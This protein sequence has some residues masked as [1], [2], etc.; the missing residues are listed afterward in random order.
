MAQSIPPSSVGQW[1]STHDDS[2]TQR[3]TAWLKES[4]LAMNGTMETQCRNIDADYVTAWAIHNKEFGGVIMKFNK[5]VK[6]LGIFILST[7]L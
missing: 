3:F 7:I 4:G 6:Q 2:K 1:L 5:V